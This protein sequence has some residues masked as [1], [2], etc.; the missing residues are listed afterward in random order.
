MPI[1]QNNG[2]RNLAFSEEVIR[3]PDGSFWIGSDLQSAHQVSIRPGMSTTIGVRIGQD[4]LPRDLR[5]VT[6][7][8]MSTRSIFMQLGLEIGSETPQII[9]YTLRSGKNG[10]L[11]A[12]IP[13]ENVGNRTVRIP[14]GMGVGCLYLWNG[15]TLNNHDLRGAIESRQIRMSGEENQDWRYHKDRH[16]VTD[17]IEY[18]LDPFFRR[19]IPADGSIIDMN[20]FRNRHDRWKIDRLL[21]PVSETSEPIDWITQTKSVIGLSDDFNALIEP[22]LNTDFF[23]VHHRNS[24]L[25]KGGDE[26]PIRLELFS[27][28]AKEP[29]PSWVLFRFAHASA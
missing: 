15:R 18:L 2:F 19:Y 25:L 28:I 12:A 6:A 10:Q 4:N 29:T 5:L 16:G 7:T 13:L 8:G 9:D 20:D 11:E 24:L 14:A 22:K 21:E 3:I 27:K 1:E 23:D 17:G 26:W